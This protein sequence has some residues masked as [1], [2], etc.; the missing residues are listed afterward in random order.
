MY[1][2][3]VI[4]PRHDPPQE[5]WISFVERT[6]GIHRFWGAFEQQLQTSTSLEFVLYASKER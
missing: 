2:K 5:G 6:T 1:V 3:R 4:Y